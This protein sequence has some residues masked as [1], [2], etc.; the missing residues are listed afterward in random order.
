MKKIYIIIIL[1]IL[2]IHI[3]N[4]QNTIGLPQIINY[5]SKDFKG[6]SQTW[7]ICQGKNGL[8]YFANNEGLL[9]FDGN[10]WNV[11]PL[12][13]KTIVRSVALGNDNKIY[14][15]GQDELGYFEADEKGLLQYH[16]LK[17]LIPQKNQHFSDI[18]NIAI[19][20]NAVYFRTLDVIFE[21]KN[22]LINTFSPF[23]TW[24][25]LKKE[26]DRI[27]AFDKERGLFYL[28]NGFFVP[29]IQ[30]QIIMNKKMGSILKIKTNEYLLITKYNEYFIMK[31]D[32]IYPY[33]I[34][35]PK[36]LTNIYINQA[37][38]LNPNNIILSTSS[39]GSY[40]IDLQGNIIQHIAKFEGLQNNNI[41]CNFIDKD[42]NFWVGLNNGISFIAFNHPFKLIQ[43]KQNSELTC[44]SINILNENIYIAS[45]DGLF[46]SPITTNLKDYSFNKNNFNYIQQSFGINWGIQQINN[47]LLVGSNNGAYTIQENRINYIDNSVGYWHFKPL[48]NIFP[49]QF[50]L[51]GTYN[52]L[53]IFEYKNNQF[54]LKNKV[55]GIKESLRYLEIDNNNIIWASH[56]Y[57]GIYQI[58]L[59]NDYTSCTYKL[60]NKLSGLPSNYGNYVFKIQQKIYFATENGVYEY[61]S[62]NDNIVYS[63][64]FNTYFGH[65]E[66]RYLKEDNW[67]NIWFCSGKQLGILKKINNHFVLEFFPELTRNYL[68][69][70]ENIY[71][72]NYQNIFI[73]SEMGIIHFN[74]EKYEKLKNNFQIII[75][76]CTFFNQTKDISYGEKFTKAIKIPF[77]LHSVH[78]EFSYPFFLKNNSIEYS[79]KLTG[80]EKE[81]SNWS[82]NTSKDY[83]NLPAGNYTFE[84]KSKNNF[85]KE[86]IISKLNFTIYPPW[87]LTIY[88]IIFY[89][90]C[91]I[92]I[93]YL[94]NKKQ[95]LKLVKQTILYEN[96]Q[97]RL[98][99]INQLELEKKE[100]E[101]IKL[102]N[103]KL[104]QEVDFKNKELVNTNL[105]LNETN[106]ALS[107]V[108][109]EVQ[110]Y[111]KHNI[112]NKDLKKVLEVLTQVEK[113]HNNWEKFSEHFDE[114]N[115]DFIKKLFSR[116]PNLSKTE[117]KLS[118]YLQLNLSTKEIAQLLNISVR[119]VEI[120]RYRL[121]KKLNIPTEESFASFF[122]KL[123]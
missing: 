28:K 78:I 54:K 60:Y 86:S 82:G 34:L 7:D 70:F 95:Q 77:N 110:K 23:S 36:Q 4:S 73:S 121:R 49:A 26:E 117:L 58:Q 14:V 33:K 80:F 102:Q 57:R 114:L 103:E 24:E 55:V 87:Y 105:H 51:A 11:Y 9:T 92:F 56:P 97:K 48:S 19:L 72:E 8:M 119:G 104:A 65:S 46:N 53:S 27:F 20:D 21:Y 40:I 16:S 42:N 89:I 45:S 122:I 2:N 61:D 109:F 25:Y 100:K 38:L 113:T 29:V 62:K 93:I 79:Y 10:Y 115:N 44:Y 31:M 111:F 71:I 116:F 75:N 81:W 63:N 67:G 101:V 98:N 37:K 69:G 30:N 120:A 35:I 99:Y 64:Y 17:E 118:A 12:P 108:K 6:G 52:G 59:N 18:W 50:V 76:Q 84:I 15:G 94:Y 41:I 22:D 96:E 5:T 13:N 88:A 39:D 83:T 32:T 107:K 66:I 47:K 123:G 1:Y 43:P 85:N 91:I 74:L 112:E 90:F 68:A 106:D 3:G